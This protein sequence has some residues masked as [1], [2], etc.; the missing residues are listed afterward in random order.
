M[1]FAIVLAGERFAADGADKGAFVGVSA[2]MGTEVIGTGKAFGA[3]VALKGCGV[4]LDA[5]FRS[6]SR[7]PGWVREF[8]DIISIG[9]G[10]G[11]GAA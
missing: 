9:D 8:K 11:G 2:E 7:G 6:G 5:L 3:E 4:F 1:A 10:R